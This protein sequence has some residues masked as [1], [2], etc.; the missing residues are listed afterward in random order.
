M[1][2]VRGESLTGGKR[3]SGGTD[4]PTI[5][6]VGRAGVGS[7]RELRREAGGRGESMI[8]MSHV[9]RVPPWSTTPP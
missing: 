1:R 9:R 5:P 6:R 2:P 4:R 3:Q 7:P 8:D